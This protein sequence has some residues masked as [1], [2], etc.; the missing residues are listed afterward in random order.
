M[1]IIYL[2]HNGSSPP[3]SLH[4]QKLFS[5][6]VKNVGNPSSPHHVGRN[7]SVALTTAR[8]AV[9][10]VLNVDVAQL[11]FTSG[12][13][14]ANNMA[15][16]GVLRYFG[17]S[18][19]HAISSAIEHPSILEPLEFLEKNEG[20]KLTLISANEFGFVAL[21]E[22]LKNITPETNLISLMAA[23]NEVGSVQS[24]KLLGDFLHYKRWGHAP[25]ENGEIILELEK[26]LSPSVTKENL[27][28]LHFHCDAV[29]VFGKVQT[30]LWFSQGID[31]C[32]ISAHKLGA[33]QGVGALFL[34]RGRKFQPLVF[35]GAQEKNRRSGTENLPAIIS[36]GLVCEEISQQN[37]WTQ[38]AEMNSLRVYFQNEISKLPNIEI[39]S[40]IQNALP[41][42][43]NFSVR[44][45]KKNGEDL[46]VELDLKGI[47]AS[48][49]SACSSGANLPSKVLLAMGKSSHLA[50]NA[51][52]L[53]MSTQTTREDVDFV[54]G[55]LQ[56][57]IN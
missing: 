57:Y 48:S 49:G 4:L 32:S 45:S 31:S 36:F 50:K 14:E 18:R 42:T 22:L 46:L 39:N 34:R 17:V 56:N 12:A 21:K 23:N 29:Q 52:R 33:L 53:S 16:T 25:L 3:S 11:I 1:K 35:G 47:C 51:V 28:K 7:A 6:L 13:T 26:H 40:P 55:C 41:N 8:R 9:A 5:L 20:L 44:A 54:L 10:Q 43:I 38:I 2:D 24:V 15:T 37:W 27:Q 30:Q 19:C